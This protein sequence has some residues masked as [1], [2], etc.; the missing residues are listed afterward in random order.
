MNSAN[1]K[2][3][4]FENEC[5]EFST[6]KASGLFVNADEQ[7]SAF[8]ELSKKQEVAEQA[9][10]EIETKKRAASNNP[11]VAKLIDRI[12]KTH[13]EQVEFSPAITEIIDN[14]TAQTAD[15]NTNWRVDKLSQYTKQ[16]R[17]L[18][19]RIFSIIVSVTDKENAEF[20]ISKI[21]D[22][23]QGKKS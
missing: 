22:G 8:E 4:D 5:K 1:K 20:I 15:K 3:A 10:K 6:K 16:E 2:I 18:I 7:K 19:T 14:N 13:E 21:E 23:L 11:I 12:E 17:K 9:R